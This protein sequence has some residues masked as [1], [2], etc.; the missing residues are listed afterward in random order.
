[1]ID[2]ASGQTIQGITG[3][4][5]TP[6]AQMQ[7]DG[8]FMM[9][10]NYLPDIIT[11][12]S[13]DYNTVNYYFN[14]TFLPFCEVSYKMTLFNN[15]GKYNRQDRSIAIR[16]RLINERHI[17]PS[18]VIGANDIYTQGS[19][20]GNQHFGVL[21]VVTT[22]QFKCNKNILGSTIGYNFSLFRHHYYQGIF[23]GLSFSPS[24]FNQLNLITEYDSNHLNVGGSCLV[25][26]HV[27]LALFICDFKDI[28]GGITYK[29]YLENN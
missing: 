7:K 11:Q 17:M 29:I 6:S 20:S 22:K 27:H 15:D 18:V 12:K 21:Y 5:N 23:G 9:G 13:F 19:D 16:G 8:T 1:M 14:I 28:V 26:N 10:I 24:F 2:F 25:L 3:L 4:L